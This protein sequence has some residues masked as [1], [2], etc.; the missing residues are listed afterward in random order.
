MKKI[1]TDGQNKTLLETTENII[2]AL[3]NIRPYIQESEEC[4][5]IYSCISMAL[6]SIYVSLLTNIPTSILKHFLVDCFNNAKSVIRLSYK[7]HKRNKNTSLT[8]I[9]IKFL[10]QI[11]YFG[12]T[13]KNLSY[14]NECVF[15]YIKN[16][17]K[18]LRKISDKRIN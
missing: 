15:S 3:N 10:W 5:T 2:Q 16:L 7:Y 1:T 6:S 8:P 17:D 4:F 14:S 11:F 18:K 9:Q 13:L 12:N